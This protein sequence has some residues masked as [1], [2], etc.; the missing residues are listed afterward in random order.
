MCVGTAIKLINTEECVAVRMHVLSSRCKQDD[1]T[2]VT[3]HVLLPPLSHNQKSSYS[4]KDNQN[5]EIKATG[6][7]C[8]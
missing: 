3:T 8:A 6:R 1:G 2:K 5:K 7:N 4:Q